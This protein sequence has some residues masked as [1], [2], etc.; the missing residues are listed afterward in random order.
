MRDEEART[1]RK[2]F[3]ASDKQHVL[4]SSDYS[5]IELRMLASMAH[6]PKMI[7]AFNEGV[8]IH[9]KTAMEIFKLKREEVNSNVRRQAKAINFGVVYGISEF[10]LAKQASIS[11][12]EAKHFKEQYFEIY[13]NIKQF[14]DDSV[15]YCKEHGYVKTLMNRRRY[16]DEINASNFMV[17]KFGER[18]AVNS[19]VQ[20]S[21]ADLIKI[22]MVKIDRE[23][24]KRGLKSKLILQI[25]DEL[26]FDVLIDEQAQMTEII[27]E[28]MKNAMNLDVTLDSSLS[29]AYSW[30]DVE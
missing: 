2:A 15:A 13:P 7:E 30:Y 18:A 29:T 20:G 21:A 11:V 19:R 1:I 28:G 12:Q 23:I 8:D 17:K 10:G 6:E 4:I 9:T 25:H 26:I 3:T 22:A 5:Q 24:K 14:E 16:I 27:K